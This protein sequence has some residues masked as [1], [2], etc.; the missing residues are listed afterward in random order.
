MKRLLLITALLPFA[1]LAQ[2]INTMN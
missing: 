2:P 1:V